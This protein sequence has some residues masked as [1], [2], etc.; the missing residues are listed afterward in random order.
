M[1]TCR[2]RSSQRKSACSILLRRRLHPLRTAKPRTKGQEK[3]KAVPTAILPR[4]KCRILLRK[5]AP[6]AGFEPATL[7]LTAGCSAIELLRNTGGP[8]RE[9]QTLI[10]PALLALGQRL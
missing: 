3:G 9:K 10:L 1:R 2:Q 8:T 6:Q 5:L 4:P 7:R